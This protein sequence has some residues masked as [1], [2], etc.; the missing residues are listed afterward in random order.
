MYVFDH[1]GTPL[2]RPNTCYDSTGIA[3]EDSLDVY[4]I[5][6]LALLLKLQIRAPE[7][8]LLIEDLPT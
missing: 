1:T 7:F 6:H 4:R 2:P 3:E 5:S 8:A